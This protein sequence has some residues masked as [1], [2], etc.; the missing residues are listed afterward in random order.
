MDSLAETVLRAT[1]LAVYGLVTITVLFEGIMTF[2]DIFLLRPDEF[3][4][5]NLYF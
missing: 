2:C 5:L 4:E 1:V 3:F